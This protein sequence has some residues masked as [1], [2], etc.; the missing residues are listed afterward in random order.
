MRHDPIFAEMTAYARDHHR[1]HMATLE[2]VATTARQPDARLWAIITKP[3][4]EETEA[5]REYLAAIERDGARTNGGQS[6][7]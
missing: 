5:D 4:S 2:P 7:G 3:V 6:N 1:R